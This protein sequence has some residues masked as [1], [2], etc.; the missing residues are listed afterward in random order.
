MIS[1]AHFTDN[2]RTG[3]KTGIPEPTPAG[4]DALAVLIQEAVNKQIEKETG[5]TEV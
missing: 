3:A 4:A 2:E 5:E 1:L